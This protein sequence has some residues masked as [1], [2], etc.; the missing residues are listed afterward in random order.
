M[1]ILLGECLPRKLKNDI[2]GHDISTVTE[3]GWTSIRNGRLLSRAEDVFDVLLTVDRNMGYQQDI[4]RYQLTLIVLL[5]PNN[6]RQTLRLLVPALLELPPMVER[7]KVY[8]LAAK[9]N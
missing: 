4:S 5:S 6:K 9:N 1:R 3:I 8:H 7:G 2:P